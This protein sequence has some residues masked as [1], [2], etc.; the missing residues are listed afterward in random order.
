MVW[1]LCLTMAN[2]TSSY[3]DIEITYELH[4][5]QS[6]QDC[7]DLT[8][9]ILRSKFEQLRADVIDKGV[10]GNIKSYMCVMEFQKRG[11]SHVHVLL[12][13]ENNSKCPVY[14][15]WM[16]QKKNSLKS[17]QLKHARVVTLI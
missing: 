3:N 14:E 5:F 9:R 12:I 6:A 2:H 11:L 13:L 10:L 4:E 16:L 7:P 15:G 8:T 17:F 1:P